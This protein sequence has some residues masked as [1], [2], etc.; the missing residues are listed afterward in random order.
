VTVP[1]NGSP[2]E[3][4]PDERRV[5]VFP[6]IYALGSPASPQRIAGA[7]PFLFTWSFPGSNLVIGID[8]DSASGADSK[9][10]V[11]FDWQTRTVTTGPGSLHRLYGV[12]PDGRRFAT[13]DHDTIAIWTVGSTQPDVK[14]VRAS[15]DYDTPLYFNPDGAMLAV[16]RCRS[17][18]LYDTATLELRVDIPI[19]NA[20]FAGFSV[21]GKHLVSRTWHGSVPEPT[22][23]PLTVD[24]VIG[25]T[26]AR[27]LSNLTSREW[28]RLGAP[29][30]NT[31]PDRG[32]SRTR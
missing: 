9:K 25:E 20:C 14:S 13:Y 28:E 30:R 22:L 18:P 26:C 29:P 6:D 12:S 24:G 15:A 31:C 16:A 4:S 21:D 32:A 8:K 27:T 2:I 3:F 19:G 17:V 7:E 11:L 1:E 10:S 23:H 5:L